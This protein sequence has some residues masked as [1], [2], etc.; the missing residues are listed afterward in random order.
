MAWHHEKSDITVGHSGN[1]EL[2]RIK[3]EQGAEKLHV[4][5]TN[6]ADK[7]LDAFDISY[8][9]RSD[10]TWQVV[11]N[12][13]SDF[14]ATHI[15]LPIVGVGDDLTTLAKSTSAALLMDVKG[16]EYVRLRASAGASSDTTITVAW[17]V[18]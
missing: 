15:Q 16:M 13:A 17:Q 9:V 14:A 12:D 8:S 7:A 3:I 18:R 1:T 10:A 4:M 2:A 6:S 11:A 5:L